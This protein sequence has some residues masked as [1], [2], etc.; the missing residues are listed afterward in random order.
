MSQGSDSGSL[1]LNN[2][3]KDVGLLFAGSTSYSIFNP[4]STVLKTVNIKLL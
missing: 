4:I 1:L 2:T 3:N